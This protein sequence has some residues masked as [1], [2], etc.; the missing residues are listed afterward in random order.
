MLPGVPTRLRRPHVRRCVEGDDVDVILQVFQQLVELLRAAA[1]VG[2]DLHLIGEAPRRPRLD[3]PQVDALLLRRGKRS[4]AGGG[5]DARRTKQEVDPSAHLK[6]PE[7]FDQT[8]DLVLQGEDHRRLP[9]SLGCLPVSRLIN[10]TEGR[11][12]GLQDGTQTAVS[13]TTTTTTTGTTY[14][15]LTAS[16]HDNIKCGEIKTNTR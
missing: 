14:T 8:A 13:N 15:T 10:G 5:C 12:P 9:S 2:E 16:D 3:V 1:A 11:T 6:E 7:S 4:A